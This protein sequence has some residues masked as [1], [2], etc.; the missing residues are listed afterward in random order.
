MVPPSYQLFIILLSIKKPIQDEK[1]E[2]K[3]WI[4]EL[5]KPRKGRFLKSEDSSLSNS[6]E[7]SHMKRNLIK[8]QLSLKASW[9]SDVDFWSLSSKWHFHD[10]K[11][12]TWTPVEYQSFSFST[13]TFEYLQYVLHTIIWWITNTRKTHFL[14][15]KGL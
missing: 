7:R 9:A 4:N 14:I 13:D 10:L 15:S 2:R 6:L 1:L 3:L 12:Y 11:H 5:E 8:S